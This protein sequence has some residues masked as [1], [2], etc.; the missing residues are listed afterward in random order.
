MENSDTIALH[1]C[2][3]HANCSCVNVLWLRT[4]FNDVLRCSTVS[5]FFEVN[6]FMGASLRRLKEGV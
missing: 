5:V 1:T 2:K 3:V 4:L 6:V